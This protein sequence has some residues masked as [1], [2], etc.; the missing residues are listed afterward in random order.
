MNIDG[1][2]E[3]KKEKNGWGFLNRSPPGPGSTQSQ[4]RERGSGRP[5]IMTLARALV[6][7]KHEK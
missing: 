1:P 4:G 3:K 5:S 7:G 2:A 6:N